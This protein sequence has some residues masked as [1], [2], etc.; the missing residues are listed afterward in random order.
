L[1]PKAPTGKEVVVIV[2]ATGT[3]L[4]TILSTLVVFPA[5]FIA[6]IVKLDVPSVVGVPVIAPLAVFKLNPAGSLP[7]ANDHVIGS[8]PVA[9]RV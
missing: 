8:V 6:L 9:V 5:A 7:L 2:G 4:M 1:L 3:G